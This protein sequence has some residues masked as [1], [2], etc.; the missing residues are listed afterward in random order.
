MLDLSKLQKSHTSS[1]VSYQSWMENHSRQRH[2]TFQPKKCGDASCCIPPTSPSGQ[3][4]WLP[5]LQEQDK[6]HYIPYE[7][8]KILGTSENDKPSLLKV[9]QAKEPGPKR[10]PTVKTNLKGATSAKSPKMNLPQC[11][12]P[13][14]LGAPW[15]IDCR[16]PRVIYARN[17]LIERQTMKLAFQLSEVD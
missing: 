7:Q 13:R 17:K 2:Y 5:V 14:M 1:V 16:I 3:L 8:A 9:A 6:D 15:C 12:L 11:L 10:K 4:H